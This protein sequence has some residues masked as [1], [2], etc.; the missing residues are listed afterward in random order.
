MLAR[1]LTE[2]EDELGGGKV[3]K[4]TEKKCMTRLDRVC[5]NLITR[6]KSTLHHVR[7]VRLFAPKPKSRQKLSV[8]KG[9]R[10]SHKR[11]LLG[12]LLR[13]GRL[14]NNNHPGA[15]VARRGHRDHLSR[16]PSAHDLQ[17]LT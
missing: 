5:R 4:L 10:P 8:E 16:A 9:S 11:L 17:N 3:V 2:Y 7:D 12:V 6:G 15:E 14:P 13:S 1:Y